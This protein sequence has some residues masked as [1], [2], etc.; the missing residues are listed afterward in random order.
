MPEPQ[1]ISYS[2]YGGGLNDA[3]SAT[4]I[5]D[6]ELAEV[7]NFEFNRSDHLKARNGFVR[8]NTGTDFTNRITSIFNFITVAGVNTLIVTSGAEIYIDTAGSYSSIKGALTLPTNTYWQWRAFTNLAIGVNQDTVGDDIVKWTGAGNA[9]ALA[10][11]GISGTPVGA[12]TIEVFNNRLWV[13]FSSHPSRLYYSTLGQAEDWGTSGGFIEVGFNDGDTIEGI[14]AHR[15]K[16]F[17]FK[18]NKIYV[19]TTDPNRSNTDPSGW[20]VDKLSEVG[21]KSRFSIQPVLD[22]LLFLTDEG[23]ASINAVQEYGEFSSAIISRKITGLSNLNMAINT[24]PAVTYTTK[25]L[26]IIAV[27]KTMTGT[28]NNRLYVLDYAK[29]TAQKLR[30]TVFESSVIN[31]S[32][33]AN[34]VVNGRKILFL[35]GDSPLF[36]ICKWD[37]TTI[38]DDENQIVVKS[39]IS[40]A[41]SFNN[42]LIRKEIDKVALGV[43]FT[44]ADLSATLNIRFNEDER[45][46]TSFS[47]NLIN[48]ALGGVWDAAIWDVD[49]FTAG[50]TNSQIIERQLRGEN[51]RRG[52]S[53]QMLFTNSQLDQD[54]VISDLGFLPGLLG[55]ENA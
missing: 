33:M 55:I 9:A 44:K 20:N 43:N 48:A 16:L 5:E 8:Q 36:H 38:F 26:Y 42:T 11:T 51:G 45:L 46:K 18:K 10:L 23:I 3:Q 2:R 21:C 30:W 32:T 6:D 12:F 52:R 31:V 50:E 35:G 28:V 19:L 27:P 39:F 41:Y 25:S 53:V 14:F 1:W 29:V 54:I 47:I 34:V 17:I 4:H 37:N 24:F 13:V 22:D 49:V 15:K 7:I 40:K